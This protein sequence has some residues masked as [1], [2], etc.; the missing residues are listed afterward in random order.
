MESADAFLTLL[1]SQPPDA[2]VSVP[3]GRVVALVASAGGELDSQVAD[4]LIASGRLRLVR[5]ADV[6]EAIAR[7]LSL[8]AAV[9]EYTGAAREL[10]TS[11]VMP[12]LRR[13]SEP[14][15][16]MLEF[17][18]AFE[19]RNRRPWE[20][21]DGTMVVRNDA[22]LRTLIAQKWRVEYS[23]SVNAGFLMSHMQRSLELIEAGG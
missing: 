14:V 17:Q 2:R 19:S 5:D 22:E 6:R 16:A 11:D 12:Y 23:A 13:T 7:Y 20:E 9:T 18:R 3:L 4:A 15:E 21:V 8:Q 1:R 10:V